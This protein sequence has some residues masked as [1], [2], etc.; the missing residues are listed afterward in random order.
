AYFMG[1]ISSAILVCRLKKLPDPRIEG[2][3]NP[4]ATNVLRIGGKNAALIVILTDT[5][6]GFIPVILA[7]IF[8]IGGLGL[9]FVGVSAVL[10]HMFPVFFEFKGGK[11][12]A[13]AFGMF[14]ALSWP[15]AILLA[16]T[17]VLVAYI[18]RYSSL[19]GITAAILA[20]VY[21]YFF[22]D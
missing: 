9:A 7:R 18:S 17:W 8:D 5:L 15:I 6:K 3:K 13:T 14:L 16:L 10:G 11:G 22:S 20:P 12:I 2:S 21:I 4:G 19:A 1:S